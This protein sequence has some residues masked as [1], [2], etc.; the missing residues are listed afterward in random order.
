MNK[1]LKNKAPVLILL[2]IV[3]IHT[4]LYSQVT[5]ISRDWKFKTGDSLCWAE[6]RYDDSGWDDIKAG[7][8]WAHAGYDYSGF[9]WYR[10]KVFISSGLKSAVKNAGY[11][12]LS[13]GQIQ[14]ADQTFLNG[15]LIG[16]TG[17]FSPFDGRWG[18]PRNYFVKADQIIWDAENNIAVRVYG[19]NRNGGMHTG[20]YIYEPYRITF[21]D[22]VKIGDSYIKPVKTNNVY[23]YEFTINFNNSG[24]K[25][26]KGE[27]LFQITDSLKAIL[28][29]QKQV[30]TIHKNTDSSNIFSFNF[31]RPQSNIYHVSAVFKELG[32]K[33]F[34]EKEITVSSLTDV[35]LPVSLRPSV[36]VENKIKDFFIP[37]PF[38]SQKIGGLLGER[39]D[40]NLSKRLLE[41]DEK[42]ILA[43][44]QYRPGKQ[45]WVGEHV[46]KYL[47]A[48]SN[49]WRYT[50]DPYLKSQMDRILVILLNTQKD[51]GYLGTYTP[52]QYWTNWD[53]WSH[54]YN[55]VGLLAYYK[56]TGYL[57]ALESAKRIGNL[58]CKTFGD[59]PGQRDIVTSGT[60]VGL[61]STSV[62]DPM[63]DLYSFSGDKKYLEFAHYI[64]RSYDHP[65]GPGIV[66]SL[67]EN[68]QV[69]KVANGKAYELLS[70]LVG[71]IKLYKLTGDEKLYKAENIAW[72]DIVE[73]RLY[74]TGTASSYELFRDEHVLPAGANDHMGEG[75]VTTTWFQLNYQLFA[76][77][78]DSKFYNQ[79]E[80][81]AYNHL[82]GAENP[83]SGCVSYYTSLQDKKP[84]SCEITCC[85]SSIPRGISMI[86]MI[87]YGKRSGVPTLLLPET[88]IIVDTVISGTNQIIPFKITT[89]SSFPDSG[90][91]VY[92]ISPEHTATFPISFRVP[93]WTT[94]FTATIE[95]IEYKGLP[96]N[97]LTIERNWKPGDKL[98]IEFDIP[99]VILP[100]G[101]SYPDRIALKRGP[102]VL[103][104][105]QSLNPA[106]Y[107]DS[108]VM[109]ITDKTGLNLFHPV[110]SLPGNWI[111]K[112]AYSLMTED[113]Q[114]KSKE[115]LL[116]PFS[117][118]SQTGADSE[119]W[120]K[121]Y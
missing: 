41:V 24:N 16:H 49:T 8:W 55:L 100:G 39:L 61:A 63:V 101:K 15:K 90:R 50:H 88:E 11:L 17:S 13:L 52:D 7:L 6:L 106:I 110:K 69:N 80:K 12:K 93:S 71:I 87:N 67:L 75:C 2:L 81:T 46:G 57:P 95:T 113:K 23:G 92:T 31:D 89:E 3:M 86:P 35:H 33:E 44:Y 18:Q 54:K 47:D 99:T 53:V 40:I 48:A 9:A 25:N 82:L 83:Q 21:K 104:L 19:P 20:P 118:A 79:L 64:I 45:N 10:K 108:L 98:K 91:M 72:N 30:V 26:Y 42:E 77:T 119:V 102:Q 65:D 112:Q 84:Y 109:R 76:L 68:G 28:L 51:D 32:T 115:I 78:G 38:E 96:G 36:V 4:S 56:A 60:H 116:I 73:N 58:L 43:G 59:N 27:L 74:I 107:P 120:L 114:G 117:D 5:V 34:I 105:D 14:D 70:N 29:S 121:D 94:R 1:I 62:L 97:F 85:L 103:A 22:Y 66:K 111:G 37:A